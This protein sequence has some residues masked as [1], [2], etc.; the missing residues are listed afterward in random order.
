MKGAFGHHRLDGQQARLWRA[1]QL[2]AVPRDHNPGLHW[3]VG[4]A[5]AAAVA[6]TAGGG[7]GGTGRMGHSA[8]APCCCYLKI[9]LPYW[10]YVGALR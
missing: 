2:L 10:L 6:A 5:I 7:G 1:P 9:P 4:L 8:N 3:G